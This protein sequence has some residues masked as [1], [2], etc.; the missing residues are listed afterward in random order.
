M[1]TLPEMMSPGAHSDTV[2]LVLDKAFSI[3][4]L[5]DKVWTE[6]GRKYEYG[7]GY[8]KQ[9]GVF[10][11]VKDK[12]GT[13]LFSKTSSTGLTPSLMSSTMKQYGLRFTVIKPMLDFATKKAGKRLKG[14]IP[15]QV[16]ST[17]R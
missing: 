8:I 10:F 9:G 12:E 17:K 5:W 7:F 4:K 16:K 13:V 14:V 11:Q 15:R 2:A 1:K 3:A 6:S